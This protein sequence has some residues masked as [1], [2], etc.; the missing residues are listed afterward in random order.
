MK[1][2][3]RAFSIIGLFAVLGST[4]N[5]EVQT[6][7][8][9]Y[10]ENGAQLEG[11]LAWDDSSDAARPGVLVVHEWWG[12]N[13]YAEN[14][15]RQLAE[16]G[17]IAFALDMYGKGQVTQHPQQA[18][19]W[20]SQIRANS[21]AWRSRANAGL[22]ILKAQP[23]VDQSKIAAIG[24]CFGGST[25]LQLAYADAP[26]RGVVSFHGALVPP[27][28][29]DTI[30]AS[31]LVCHGA[32]DSFVPPESVQGFEAAMQKVNADYQLISYG[33]ARHGFTNPNAGSFGI[34]NL[35]YDALAD[36]R[37]W[38]QMQLFLD[39]IFQSKQ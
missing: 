3:Y 4:L 34:E 24:Y 26:V 25:V 12:L 36:S 8:I 2:T 1:P 5:A 29:S 35:K 14:R 17:Y 38:D 19:E 18:G 21:E 16:L 30:D 7:R 11:V 20:S 33:G 22:D 32:S 6:R 13:D 37:S 15:A 31:V 28:E 10:E 23:M 39:E 9:A 27:S